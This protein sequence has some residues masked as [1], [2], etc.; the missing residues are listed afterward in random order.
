LEARVV[1]SWC[2]G[3]PIY[4]RRA[5]LDY[6]HYWGVR[7]SGPSDYVEWFLQEYHEKAVAGHQQC[8]CI[9]RERAARDD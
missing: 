2:I 4:L 6:Q 3:C 1:P 7:H 8:W 5:P 9:R